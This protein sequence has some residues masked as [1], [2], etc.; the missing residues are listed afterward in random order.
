MS[1]FPLLTRPVV[2][3]VVSAANFMPAELH[4]AYVLGNE[5]GDTEFLFRYDMNGAFYDAEFANATEV[6]QSLSM[7]ADIVLG[8]RDRR[9]RAVDTAF[10]VGSHRETNFD[11]DDGVARDVAIDVGGEPVIEDVSDRFSYKA[12]GV[13]GHFTHTLGRVT[14]ALDL[15]FER[16]EYERTENVANYDQDYFLYGSRDRFRRQR[17]HAA[18]FGLRQ[19]RTAIR[20][21]ARARSDG[22]AARH[23]PGTEVHP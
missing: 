19:Y 10:F 5:A 17:R 2:V 23:E 18:S 9:R 6:D 4:A 12:S 3:P 20:R 21:A 16:D 8:E 13:Q 1:I 22:R 7:G 15:R 11:P 14:W